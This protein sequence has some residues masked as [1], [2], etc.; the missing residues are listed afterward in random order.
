MRE[1]LRPTSCA[2]CGLS[3]NPGAEICFSISC[4]DLR[5]E[6]RSKIAPNRREPVFNFGD[7]C[8]CFFFHISY[9]KG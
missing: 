7:F 4:S 1:R 2:A 5:A 9:F 8:Q 3:Q 6:S